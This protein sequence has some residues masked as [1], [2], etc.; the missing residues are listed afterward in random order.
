MSSKQHQVPSNARD[1]DAAIA[2]RSGRGSAYDFEGATVTNND[3]PLPSK[4]KCEDG[5]E[6]LNHTA[7]IQ[8]HS[9][10]TSFKGALEQLVIAMFGYMTTLE[11]IEIDNEYSIQVASN[12][13]A[14]G[15]DLESLVFNY[16][17]D[18]LFLFHTTFFIPKEVTVSNIDMT[19]FSI[20]SSGMGEKLNLAKHDQGTEIKAI[21]Y[22]N[23][24]VNLDKEKCDIYVIVD[25]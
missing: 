23:M 15:H 13:H 16:L 24:Q 9:W 22:S 14:E 3:S 7:D 17:D 5:Y 6:Y 10:S 11:K 1:I 21:T 2:K 8:L 20:Q 12:V 4:R 19:N 18:W 25:I